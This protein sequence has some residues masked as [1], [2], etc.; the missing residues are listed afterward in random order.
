[1]RQAALQDNRE[2]VVSRMTGKRSIIF[3]APESK[4][5]GPTSKIDWHALPNLA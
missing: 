5:Q 1:M 3:L 2:E 4:G